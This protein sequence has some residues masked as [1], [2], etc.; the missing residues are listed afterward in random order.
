MNSV[1][2]HKEVYKQFDFTFAEYSDSK[3]IGLEWGYRLLRSG[4]I[5]QYSK[6]LSALVVDNELFKA[7]VL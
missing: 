1:V 7:N 4:A 2:I 3:Y 5:I 6:Q